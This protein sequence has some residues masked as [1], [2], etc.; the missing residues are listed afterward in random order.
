MFFIYTCKQRDIFL[1]RGVVV[2][3]V[4]CFAERFV[5]CF[6]FL[7]CVVLDCV[8]LYRFEFC[9][10]LLCFFHVFVLFHSVL[11]SV[12]CAV[13]CVLCLRG[14]ALSCVVLCLVVLCSHP[15]IKVST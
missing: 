11:Y 10:G 4:L 12:H 14:T 5:L 1:L 8:E 6:A 2:V 13:L 7:C 9:F 3:V 15:Y